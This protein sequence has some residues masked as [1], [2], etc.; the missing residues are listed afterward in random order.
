MIYSLIDCHADTASVAL[1]KNVGFFN[2]GLHVDLDD[3]TFRYTQFFAA[4]IAPEYKSCAFERTM[5]IIKKL[6]YEINEQAYLFLYISN[7][8]LRFLN[9]SCY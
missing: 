2:N 4:F 8:H 7:Y 9:L 1:D 5:N 6:K 3:V